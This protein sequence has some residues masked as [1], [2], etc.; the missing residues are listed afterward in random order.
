[1]IVDLPQPEAP[2]K[3]VLLPALTLN[4]MPFKMVFS[5]TG[6]LNTTFLNSISP[7]TLAGRRSLS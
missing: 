7:I 1:M 6:Y 3:A 5:R 2:T 4:E